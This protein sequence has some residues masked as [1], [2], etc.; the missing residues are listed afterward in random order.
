MS[1]AERELT[2]WFKIAI[3]EFCKKNSRISKIFQ[4]S[5]K[6]KIPPGFDEIFYLCLHRWKQ[7]FYKGMP[8]TLRQIRINGNLSESKWYIYLDIEKRLNIENTSI[9]SAGL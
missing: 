2:D 3:C 4:G 6:W 5:V 9:F 8:F 1:N 7:A